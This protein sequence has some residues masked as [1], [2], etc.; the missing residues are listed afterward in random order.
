MSDRFPSLNPLALRATSMA[1]FCRL[2]SCVLD[3]ERRRRRA[4]KRKDWVPAGDTWF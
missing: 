2:A 1:E 3:H 4:E